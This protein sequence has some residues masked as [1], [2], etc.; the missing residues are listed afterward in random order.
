M[1]SVDCI[2]EGLFV[3]MAFDLHI[4][5]SRYIVAWF[6]INGTGMSRA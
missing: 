3:I 2:Y 1:I 6:A 5:C 4:W